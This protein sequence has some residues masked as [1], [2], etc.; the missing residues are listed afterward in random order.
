VSTPDEA[1]ADI[2]AT[3]LD[4][5]KAFHAAFYG[6]SA[7]DVAVI[8]DF[9][10]GQVTAAVTR[11][12]GD[13]KS[14]E[15]FARIVRAYLP[16]DSSTQSIETPDKANAAYF[17]GQN[18]ALRDDD[19]DYAAM[20]VANFVIGG[21]LLSSR[22]VTRLRQKEG[23]SYFV[24]S[25]LQAQPLDRVGTFLTV[26]IYAPQNADRL[27]AAMREELDKVRTEGFTQQEIDA[28][29][30]GYIQGR[31]QSRANDQELVGMLVNRRFANRTLAYD[32][33]FERRVQA[34]TPDQVNATVKKYLDPAKT[35]VVRA[36]DFAKH[37]AV[38]A[39]P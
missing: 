5:V 24:T 33:E 4:Q 28:A 13:W 2:N 25:Q 8:G 27:M 7:G 29:K 10:A 9:D 35:V 12:F 18:L 16:V 15:P 38:K 14:P 39:T 1:I 23:I 37:P 3:T 34:L 21:G 30:S 20:A 6:A 22:L 11:L 26:A 17:A 32:A 19:P 31:S 36:G